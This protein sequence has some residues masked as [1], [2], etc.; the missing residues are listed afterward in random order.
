MAWRPATTAFGATVYVT[1]PLPCPL[2]EDVIASQ[3]A[4]LLAVHEHSRSVVTCRVPLAPDALSVGVLAVSV[5]A[6]RDAVGAV[7]LVDE[8]E[9]QLT[10]NASRRLQRL[11][12]LATR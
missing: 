1:V 6:H 8:E 11:Q 9:P 2:A 4:S 10:Q 3:S 12:R 5:S 7:T